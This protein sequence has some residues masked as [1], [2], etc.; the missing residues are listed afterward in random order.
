[1]GPSAEQ[2]PPPRKVS[3]ASVLK[4]QPALSF[5][6]LHQQEFDKL[7]DEWLEDDAVQRP[8]MALE[9]W[10][11]AR[12]LALIRESGGSFDPSVMHAMYRQQTDLVSQIQSTSQ[13]FERCCTVLEQLVL[14]PAFVRRVTAFLH[15]HHLAFVSSKPSRERG[16]FSHEDFLVYKDYSAMVQQMVLG[17]L[18][19]KVE[20]FD[21][22]EFFDALFD[23]PASS[24][25]DAAVSGG[26]NDGSSVQVLSFEVWEILLS[27]LKFENFCDVMDDYITSHYNTSTYDSTVGASK[28]SGLRGAVKRSS[29]PPSQAQV[30]AAPAS[31]ASSQSGSNSVRP[32]SIATS[33][34]GKSVAGLRAKK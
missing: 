24:V 29:P 7:Y 12:T 2:A 18:A 30:R 11:K 13:R 9:S 32:T 25:V 34:T 10:E 27:F 28:V 21:V 3:T 4:Q 26:N 8:F 5:A 20:S 22:D 19:A 16:E 33:T 1:V 23:T 31:A 6:Q 17:E 14:N 15:K